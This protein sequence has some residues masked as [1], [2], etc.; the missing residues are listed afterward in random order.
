MKDKIKKIMRVLVPV[1]IGL[2]L[3]V[4]IIA[5]YL[6][7]FPGALTAEKA[8]TGYIKASLQQD[9]S[10]M[11]RY[12]SDYQKVKL[13]GNKNFTNAALKEK[14]EKSYSGVEN[15]YADST[16]AFSVESVTEVDPDSDDYLLFVSEYMSV[17][18][19]NDFSKVEKIT[20][21]VFVDGKQQ[22]KQTVY[23]IKSGISWY[24]GY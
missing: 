2:G 12:A 13:Y 22:Q 10:A 6:F 5:S 19:N 23:A 18:G 24:Y 4:L 3:A 17:T 15:I 11:V 9:A 7:L 14:L 20:V 1:L 21:K 8:V 16:I